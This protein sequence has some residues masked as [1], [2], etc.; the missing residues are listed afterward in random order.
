MYE[1]HFAQFKKS[2]YSEK[3]LLSINQT[4]T[5]ILTNRLDSDPER[6]LE[7]RDSIELVESPQVLFHDNPLK[8]GFFMI[9]IKNGNNTY[10]LY[11]IL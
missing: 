1:P 9:G 2:I 8:S 7:V 3:L 6:M 11:Q 5:H 4:Q 10:S